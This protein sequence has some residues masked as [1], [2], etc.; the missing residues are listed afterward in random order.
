MPEAIGVSQSGA[1]LWMSLAKTP[2]SCGESVDN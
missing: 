2:A 1:S